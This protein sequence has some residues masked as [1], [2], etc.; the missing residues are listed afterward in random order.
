M[1]K[2]ESRLGRNLTELAK[3]HFKQLE[4]S[5]RAKL[6][7]PPLKQRQYD[8]VDKNL[9][10]IITAKPEE[11]LS[12]NKEYEDYCT[13]SGFGRLK[14]LKQ[15]LKRIFDYEHFSKKSS[16]SYDGYDFTNNLQISTCPY[17]NRG[18]VYTVTKGKDKIVRPDI[19][20]FYAKS[21][22]PLLALSFFNLVPSCLVCNRSIK[23]RKKTSTC[24]NPYIDGFGDAMKFS[25]MPLD[26]AS[27]SG[28]GRKFSVTF[29][30]DILQISKVKRCEKNIEL[31]RLKEIYAESHGD[32]I[33]HLIS[34]F[35]KTNGAYLSQLQKMFPKLGSIQ[36][37]YRIA[38]GNYLKEED[39]D[40]KTLA[41]FTKDIVDQL[42]FTI[43]DVSILKS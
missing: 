35:E 2:I 31:F 10:K 6:L 30:N 21:D 5:I 12:V 34:L 32:E 1:I 25:F 11:L 24:L 3:E 22:Y 43:S 28:N 27:A 7:M 13:K 8:Y 37:F 18:Y 20:H 4:P 9:E 33:A 42:K 39:Y 36:E 15:G 23:G 26:A 17:C 29:S 38:F 16:T 40:K 19:D 41:K 14:N